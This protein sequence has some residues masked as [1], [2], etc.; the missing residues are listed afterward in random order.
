MSIPRKF[1]KKFLPEEVLFRLYYDDKYYHDGKQPWGKASTYKKLQNWVTQNVG[2]NPYTG[3][4]FS[5]AAIQQAQWR[6]ALRNLE[7]A[8]DI[9][10]DYCLSFGMIPTGDE[11]KERINGFARNCLKSSGYKKFIQN[12]PEYSK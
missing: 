7:D 3:N 11:W 9:Y 5:I 8:K 2:V 6:W 4:P 1:G 10:V 12:H